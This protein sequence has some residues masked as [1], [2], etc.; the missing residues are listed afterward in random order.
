MPKALP[1]QIDELYQSML[2]RLPDPDARKNCIDFVKSGGAIREL[3]EAIA[4]S[5]EYQSWKGIAANIEAVRQRARSRPSGFFDENPVSQVPEIYHDDLIPFFTYHGK[6]R[7]LALIIET[8]NICNNDC[9]ICPYSMQHRRKQTMDV[10]LFAKI[11]KDY[12]SIGGGNLGLTPMTGEIFLD[13]YLA[14]RLEI[15]KSE[16]SISSVSVITNASTVHRFND[17]QLSNL[18]SNFD[19]ISVSVYGLDP[20]EY[21]VMTR[22]N[23]YDRMLDG[24]VRLLAL[25]GPKKIS[26]S[27]RHLKAR[28]PE[29]VASWLANIGAQSKVNSSDIRYDWTRGYANWGV[30]DT[31]KELPF[32]AE[33]WPVRENRRQCAMP[34]VSA[35]VLSDGTVSFCACMDFDAHSGLVLGNIKES[36]FA[37]LFASDKVRKLWNWA[38]CGVPEF[39][40]SC[41]AHRPIESLLRMPTVFKA[42]LA[43][44]GS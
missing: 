34:L 14:E 39:C 27:I 3:A 9:I 36:T 38:E 23:Q 10:G 2:G 44:F 8:I 40:K 4:Q 18:I 1:D 16:P 26:L 24:I 33:W 12:S 30:F 28:A 17:A 42:P 43:A 31:A 29:Q 5:E 13:K 7:P 32:E 20:E 21:E 22:K 19:R 15:I 6:Y 37:E 11:I 25:G 41:T 35:Q